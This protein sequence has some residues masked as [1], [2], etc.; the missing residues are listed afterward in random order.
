MKALVQ[1]KTQF[2]IARY[3]SI[4]TQKVQSGSEFPSINNIEKCDRKVK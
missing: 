1:Q 2:T 3:H 4:I